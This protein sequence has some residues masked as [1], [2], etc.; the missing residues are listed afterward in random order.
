MLLD[1]EDV[2]TEAAIAIEEIDRVFRLNF[3]AYFLLIY[4]IFPGLQEALLN[5]NQSNGIIVKIL[6]IVDQILSNRL[7][8]RKARLLLLHDNL[9]LLRLLTLDLVHVFHIGAHRLHPLHLF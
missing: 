9:D 3:I 4:F 8:T 7:A 5:Q 1:V 6:D 2:S